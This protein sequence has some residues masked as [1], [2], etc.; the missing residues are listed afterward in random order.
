MQSSLFSPEPDDDFENDVVH[1]PVWPFPDHVIF[2]FGKI[3]VL[4]SE[5]DSADMID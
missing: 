1:H 3:N 4:D 5:P 2:A